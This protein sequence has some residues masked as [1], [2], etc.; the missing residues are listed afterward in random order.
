MEVLIASMIFS[1]VVGAAVTTL[2][3]IRSLSKEFEYRYTAL[4][5]ARETLE[6]GEASRFGHQFKMKYY[7]PAATVCTIP[8]GC[9][10]DPTSPCGREGLNATEGY[11]LKEWWTF[12]SHS[13][14]PFM[15]LGDIK[16]K[17]LVPVRAPDS[18]VI[19]YTA[20]NNATVRGYV[21]TATITWQEDLGGAKK[22][23]ILSVIPIRQVN[24][25]LQ[26]NTAEFWWE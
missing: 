4:N 12:C 5:L 14:N 2:V 18:V 21:E 6:F 9:D 25:Q 1:L 19:Y 24:D 8:G 15:I 11:G 20:E 23:E 26:L 7:Y 16:A 10:N 17:K 13:L 22:N 3:S